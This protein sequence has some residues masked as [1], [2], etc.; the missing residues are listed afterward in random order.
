MNADAQRSSVKL[1]NKLHWIP[2]YEE[3][4]LAKCCLAFKRLHNQVPSYLMDMLKLTRYANLQFSF[5]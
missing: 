3:A 1:L 2:F 5:H 4:K